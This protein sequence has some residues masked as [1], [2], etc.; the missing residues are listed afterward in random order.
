MPTKPFILS[1]K[2]PETTKASGIFTNISAKI[3]QFAFLLFGIATFSE[4]TRWEEIQR[5]ETPGS[6]LPT[7][8]LSYIRFFKTSRFNKQLQQRS[9]SSDFP[10]VLPKC[11]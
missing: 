5:K 6:R 11:A 1:N 4:K 2:C 9:W 3:V 8:V 7:E 10:K